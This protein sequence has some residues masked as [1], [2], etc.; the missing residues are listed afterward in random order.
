LEGLPSLLVLE[1]TL[2]AGKN[3][4]GRYGIGLAASGKMNPSQK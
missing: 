2:L 4:E 3:I 1:A